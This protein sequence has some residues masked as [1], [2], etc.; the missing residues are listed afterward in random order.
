MRANTPK[1]HLADLKAEA[2]NAAPEDNGLRIAGSGTL[3]KEFKAF[4]QSHDGE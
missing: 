3:G 2:A 4:Q 1:N